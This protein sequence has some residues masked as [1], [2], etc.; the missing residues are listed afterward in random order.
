[1]VAEQVGEIISGVVEMTNER[2]G[3][4]IAG[5]WHQVSKF[6][7]DVIMPGRG[8]AVT[9]KLDSKGFVRA[10]TRQGHAPG[11][12]VENAGAAA[13]SRDRSIIRQVALKAAVELAAANVAAGHAF[14][15]EDAL[16]VA[17]KFETWLNRPFDQDGAGEP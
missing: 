17:A 14:K 1:M 6:A 5:D 12:P 8:E 10:V 9:L 13:T 2:G 7:K 15:S 3:I 11:S 4:R 16:V